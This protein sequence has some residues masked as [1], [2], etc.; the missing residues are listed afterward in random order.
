MAD[1]RS[2]PSMD[3]ILSSIKRIIADDD[4]SRPATKRA[5]SVAREE[6]EEVLELTTAAENTISE[7]RLLD[8]SKAQNLRHSFSALQT[9]SE[10]GVAPQIVRSGET[11]LEGLTR[12]LLRPMLK[13]WLD[14]HLPPIVEAMVEREITRITKKG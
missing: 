2:E 12:E 7:D 3:E 1:N 9:L 8:D 6:E 14:T 5:K 11:S 10:P 13:D 4:R